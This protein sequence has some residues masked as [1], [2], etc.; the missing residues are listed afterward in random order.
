MIDDQE[1]DYILVRGM[2][3]SIPNQ[4]FDL[5][6][7]PSFV[8]GL[9]AIRPEAHDVCLI[10]CRID[11]SD[12]L[13]L[14]KRAREAGSKAPVI[15]LTGMGDYQLNEDAMKLGAVDFLARD[16]LTASLLERSM[17]YAMAQAR[18]LDELTR[19]R[20]ELRASELRFRSVV[21]SANDAIILAD[22]SS[23]IIGWNR[24]AEVIFGY[25]E[26]EVLG[27]PIELL[28]PERHR[29][30]HRLGFRRFRMGGRPHLV[31]KTVQLEGLRKDGSD[32]PLELSLASWTSDDGTFFT[33][34]IRDI[35]ERK[36]VE[37][38]RSARETAE[39]ASR[40]K[41]TFVANVS[42]ELRIPLHSIIG[43]TNLLLKNRNT[44]AEERDFLERILLNAKDQLALINS[45]L[46]LSKIERGKADVE[47][48]P[49]AVDE[50]VRQV[51]RQL[52]LQ[53]RNPD[54][55]IVVR[56]PQSIRP[57]TT[58]GAKLKQVLI[59]LIENALKFTES[60]SVIVNVAASPT[61]FSPLR[62]DV[63]DT[64]PGIPPHQLDDIFEPFR[65]V[66]RTPASRRAGTG[67][68]LAISR[69]LCELLGYD[70]RVQSKEGRG[71]TF[72]ILLASETVLPLS[73]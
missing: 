30:K 18:A 8:A 6:W 60:G 55:E 25:T 1:P 70:L 48:R 35:S 33:G 69:S 14:L 51:V 23:R 37:E 71:S 42:H 34:I 16:Q 57:I 68:G 66:E 28:M 50:I 26:D 62:I 9:E 29:E 12:G 10:D 53:R 72:S 41:S 38:M 44:S 20:D 11:A 64:G 47:A 19:Q 17:R 45:I 36:R 3:S 58:D 15:L 73:A 27:F 46:N 56:V 2:L 24:G 22:E 67:L 21:Q 54:V 63:I 59:N 13:E 5:E 49:V 31:G 39:E 32:F 4:A 52:E 61:D 40:A 43:F 7:A 65:Q